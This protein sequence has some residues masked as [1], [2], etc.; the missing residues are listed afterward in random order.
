MY[1]KCSRSPDS[2]RLEKKGYGEVIH[3]PVEFE[4]FLALQAV[5]VEVG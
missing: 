1:G 4:T 3:F 5:H 2:L